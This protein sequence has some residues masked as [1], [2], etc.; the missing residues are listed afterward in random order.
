MTL[1][2]ILKVID[3]GYNA[4]SFFLEYGHLRVIFVNFFLEQTIFWNSI[5]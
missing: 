2:V 4:F 3:I 1:T 5:E